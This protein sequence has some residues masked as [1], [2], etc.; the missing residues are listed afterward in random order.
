MATSLST[1]VSRAFGGPVGN[2]HRTL[3]LGPY[4]KWNSA[5]VRRMTILSRV[6]ASGYRGQV[7]AGALDLGYHRAICPAIVVRVPLFLTWIR[8]PAA[9]VGKHESPSASAKAAVLP[10]A[11]PARVFEI[12][13]GASEKRPR[14]SNGRGAGGGQ[15]SPPS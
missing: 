6:F 13:G 10:L 11:F 14:I 7:S 5:T 12:R 1:F 9:G 4:Y 8:Y 2:V 3:C 15:R